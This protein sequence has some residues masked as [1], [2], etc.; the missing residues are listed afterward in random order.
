MTSNNITPAE[1]EHVANLAKLTLTESE[2][3]AF[4]NQL[5]KIFEVVDTLSEV[6]TDGIEPTYSMTDGA[7]KLRSD[8]AINAN[9]RTE[10]LKNAPETQE[11]L[12]KVP[13]ILTA[14]EDK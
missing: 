5:D 13:A 12:I 1:V 7:N 2:K 6:D 8:E 10:L 3:M 9:Q 11:T 14:G 4:T